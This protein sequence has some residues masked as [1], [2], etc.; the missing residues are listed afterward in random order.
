M[1]LLQAQQGLLGETPGHTSPSFLRLSGPARWRA[2]GG[3]RT[4]RCRTQPGARRNRRRKGKNQSIGR[5]QI[6]AAFTRRRVLAAS[7]FLS[8]PAVTA[9]RTP[10]SSPDC[11]LSGTE[12]RRTH[13]CVFLWAAG[14]LAR[15]SHEGA[16]RSRSRT[17]APRTLFSVSAAARRWPCPG[18]RREVVLPQ[19][20][21]HFSAPH[22]THNHVI[23]TLTLFIHGRAVCAVCFGSGGSG[24][25]L[26]LCRIHY[27]WLF[28]ESA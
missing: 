16:A 8:G 24:V 27:I 19:R 1:T 11:E 5:V 13:R 7:H 28:R 14:D 20:P 21:G 18:L 10:A 12:A 9:P 6:H 2:R 22:P 26:G 17:L 3:H 25:R 23:D 4:R 15:R